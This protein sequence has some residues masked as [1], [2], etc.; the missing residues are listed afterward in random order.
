MAIEVA[1]RKEAEGSPIH[2]EDTP[3]SPMCV[4]GKAKPAVENVVVISR[5]VTLRENAGFTIFFSVLG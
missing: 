3:V 5:I 1:E 2:R 4:E